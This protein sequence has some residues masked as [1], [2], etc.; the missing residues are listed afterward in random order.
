MSETERPTQWI[1]PDPDGPWRCEPDGCPHA[2]TRT[3]TYV[4]VEPGESVRVCSDCGTCLLPPR[5]P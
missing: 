3:V 4:D 1:K 2:N 5:E